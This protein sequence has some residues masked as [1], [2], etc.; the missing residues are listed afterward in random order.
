MQK[1]QNCGN[2]LIKALG[3]QATTSA[4]T[5][6]FRVYKAPPCDTN[7]SITNWVTDEHSPEGKVSARRHRSLVIMYP[8]SEII[9]LVANLSPQPVYILYKTRRKNFQ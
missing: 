6:S 4:T 7:R 8:I 5:L 9:I 1:Q 3:R 2:K